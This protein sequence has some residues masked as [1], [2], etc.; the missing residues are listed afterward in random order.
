M[1]FFFFWYTKYSSEYGINIIQ[2]LYDIER[3]CI[4]R[5]ET[6]K[7]C[8][9]AAIQECSQCIQAPWGD[10][11]CENTEH[12]IVGEILTTEPSESLTKWIHY[13]RILCNLKNFVDEQLT[14][15]ETE[16]VMICTNNFHLATSVFFCYSFVLKHKI[17]EMFTAQSSLKSPSLYYG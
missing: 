5:K 3:I 14:C 11:G 12:C 7:T 10:S 4:F 13:L 17:Y 15:R 1:R 9:L 8:Q 16:G 2:K 6:K